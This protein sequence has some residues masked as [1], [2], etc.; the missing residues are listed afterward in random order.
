ML[1]N[2]EKWLIIMMDMCCGFEL[3]KVVKKMTPTVEDPAVHKPPSKSPVVEL[4]IL[5][6]V[7]GSPIHG[8]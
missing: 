3:L 5:V 1:L 7:Y 4:V 2:I 8:S 6:A